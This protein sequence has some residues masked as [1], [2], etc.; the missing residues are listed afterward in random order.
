MS[1]AGSAS[2]RGGLPRSRATVS[3]AVLVLH[4]GREVSRQV[5][6]PNQLAVL[7][8]L[9]IY[10]GLRRRSSAAAVY[11][12]KYRLRGWNADPA[13]AVEPAPVVD[14]RWALD[15]ITARHGAVPVVLLG[16]SMGGRTAFAVADDPRV[17]GVCALAPWLPAGEPLV[18]TRRDQR[19]VIAHGTAD[20][21][22]SA[23]GSLG[24]AQ[25]LRAAGASVARLELSGGRHALLEKARLWHGLAV[26]VSLGLAGDAALPPVVAAALGDST[27]GSLRLAMESARAR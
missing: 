1:D 5:T 3:S 16:H 14:V 13:G 12:L 27:P 26:E 23:A 2:L 15:E 9:D 7:R 19:F 11:L 20:R 6:A 4:G 18:T 22:T 24:Y 25:R 17:A 8:M 21:T 10:V